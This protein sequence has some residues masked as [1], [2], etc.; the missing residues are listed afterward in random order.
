MP[1][2]NYMCLKC[3]EIV[4]KFQHKPVKPKI[5]CKKCGY[6]KF[7]RIIGKIRN[8]ITYNAKDTYKNRIKPDVD[9]INKN[10]SDGKDKDFLDISG[11]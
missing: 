11:D 10:I 3:D 7:K 4:E 9:R 1:L 2:F 8:K 5:G 6:K